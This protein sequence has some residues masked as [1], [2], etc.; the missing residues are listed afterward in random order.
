MS[1]NDPPQTP[2]DQTPPP[3]EP[4]PRARLLRSTSD[5]MVAGVAGGLGRYFGIDPVIIRI[6]FVV[7]TFFGGAGVLL[8]VAAILLIP[9]D[10]QV[11][12]GAA[13]AGP[14]APPLGGER[15]RG[16][17]IL[18]VILLVLVAGPLLFGPALIAGSIIVPIAFLVLLGLGVAWLVT[19]KRP[20]RDAASIVR[21]TLLGLGVVLLLC[22]LFVGAFWAAGLGGDVVVAGLVIVAGVA[23]L[24]AAFSRP[25]RWLILPAL[26]IAMPAGF[27]AAAGI[28]L[29]GGIGERTYRPVSATQIREHY[30]VGTGRLVVDLRQTDLSAGDRTIDVD[31]GMGEAVV[32]VPDDVCV[33]TDARVGM[34]ATSVFEQTNGGIDV[35]TDEGG[36]ARSGA[37]RLLVD[38]NIGLGHLDIRKTDPD[39]RHWEDSDNWNERAGS[40]G[41]TTAGRASRAGGTPPV[42]GSPDLPSVVAGFALIAFGG[43]LL[44]DALGA[45]VLTF[46]ALGP[47][48]CAVI[49]AILLAL[50]LGRE[51]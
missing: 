19:G 17:V 50:G 14:P 30:E 51:T 16:L 18:G 33:A 24:V 43:V 40:A 26:A 15:N 22:V 46:E 25:A 5:R 7:L 44:A 3:S 21:A 29:D 39:V 8:Y 9:S 6:A 12:G 23:V 1:A 37:G 2:E 47:I 38:A 35:D 20:D 13:A 34:G 36:V 31:V 48:V 28:D 11:E 42:R 10:A 32:V 27:V 49:G 45:F 41:R 4:A